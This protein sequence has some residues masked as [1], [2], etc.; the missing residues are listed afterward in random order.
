MRPCPST[1]W[2]PSAVAA[3][4]GTPSS[5]PLKSIVTRSPS[6]AGRAAATQVSALLA[7]DVD[8][9]VDLGVTHRA[10]Q[11]LD[12]ERR[13]IAHDDVGVDLEG[14]GEAELAFGRVF[15]AFDL[16]L[17]GHAQECSATASL[18]ALETASPRTSDCT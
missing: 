13:H 7:Q 9:L 8:G 3:L 10:G 18:N 1:T 17:A 2:K 15:A 14:R 6:A 16:R 12:L 11:A 4:E 5:V